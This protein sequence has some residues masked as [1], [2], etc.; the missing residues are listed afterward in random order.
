MLLTGARV[1]FFFS[2]PDNKPKEKK[3][4]P[5]YIKALKLNMLAKTE[6]G[7]AGCRSS[8]VLQQSIPIQIA[9]P[10]LQPTDW[11]STPESDPTGQEKSSADHCGPP[12]VRPRVLV[13]L[14]VERGGY[15]FLHQPQLITQ[16][17]VGFH[18]VLDLGFRG[19]KC[20]FHLHVFLHS[21][22]AIREV[23]V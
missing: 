3:K 18:E 23:R 11:P 21:N 20:I 9:R 16:V 10:L 19:R 2:N 5:V 13:I 8:L 17:V 15:L 7:P 6:G 1:H 4:S 14:L 22:G 12:S